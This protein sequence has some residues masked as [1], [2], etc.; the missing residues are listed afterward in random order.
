MILPFLLALVAFLT[1]LAILAPLLHSRQPVLDRASYDQAVYRDQLRE[2][3]RDVA[4]GL[5]PPED[6]AAARLEIQRRLLATTSAAAKSAVVR[7]VRAPVASAVRPASRR[8]PVLAG[9]LFVVIGL[10]SVGLY[11]RLGSP[12]IPDEPFAARPAEMAAA[13]DSARLSMEQA[14]TQ[15]AAKLQA[16][17]SDQQG[18]LLYGRTLAMLS[19][20]A[21]AEDAYRHAMALG[22]TDP[23]VAGVHAEMLVL[24]AGGTV[25]PAAEAAFRQIL[26]TD[27]D[28]GMAHYYLAIAATQAGEPRRAIDML[29]TLLAH[30]PAN[31]PLRAQ[32]GQ[33]VAEAAQAAHIAVPELAQGTAPMPEATATASNAKAPDANAVAA[34]A[35]M[36]DA[37]RQAMIQ[38]MVAQLAAKQQADPSNLDG[39]LQLARAYSVL[40]QPDK[41]AAAYER[42]ASLKPADESIPLQEA[43]ALLANH[44]PTDKLPPRVVDLLKRVQ[45]VNPQN[46]MVLWFLGIAAAQDRQ[47]ESARRYWDALLAQLQPASDDARMVQAALDTLPRQGSAPAAASGASTAAPSKP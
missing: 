35:Q 40:H 4:R 22:A 46:P 38:G 19:H 26:A 14:A 45:A 44:Q 2:L 24:A 17:P 41:A 23:E 6:A 31:S 1:L 10:S 36:S 29:Q 9:A 5:S 13:D 27:P 15:I 37:Q 18:W 7:P 12:G 42:A 33:R 28:N 34:A 43:R 3:E 16:N 20:W 30:M 11:M 47:A 39:W 32:V 25:T 21:Q 8:S